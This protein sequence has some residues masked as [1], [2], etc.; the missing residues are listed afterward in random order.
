MSLPLFPLFPCGE[1]GRASGDLAAAT[2]RY[3]VKRRTGKSRR[4]LGDNDIGGGGRD[5]AW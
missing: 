4:Y 1:D 2:S 5:G 3:D